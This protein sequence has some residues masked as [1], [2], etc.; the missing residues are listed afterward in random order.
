MNTNIKNIQA[1]ILI[2]NDRLFLS[3]EINFSNV[4]F[5]YQKSLVYF[6]QTDRV[7]FQIDCSRLANSHSV[8]LAL[9][10][11]WVKLAHQVNQP[12]RFFHLSIKLMALVKSAGMEELFA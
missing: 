5:I 4:N 10:I 7:L 2:E 11:E 3:G 12:I 1:D 6:K 9:L 8:V